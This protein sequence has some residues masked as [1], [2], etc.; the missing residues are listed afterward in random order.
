MM[1]IALSVWG[2]DAVVQGRFTVV[3]EMVENGSVC[4]NQG[5]PC[6]VCLK[7]VVCVMCVVDRAGKSPL[8]TA[9]HHCKHEIMEYLIIK[10]AVVCSL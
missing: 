9:G 4:V 6:G 2:A 7:L 10:G 3:E 8:M 1:F 5:S